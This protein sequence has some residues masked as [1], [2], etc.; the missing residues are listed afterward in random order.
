MTEPAT[1]ATPPSAGRVV[2]LYTTL[3]LL[4]FVALWLVLVLLGASPVAGAL[5]AAVLTSLLSLVL[6]RKQ[7]DQVSAAVLARHERKRLEREELQRRLD[8]GPQDNHS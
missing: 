4:L 3:R 1:P 5:V 7:R 8:Q 6:L 2:L